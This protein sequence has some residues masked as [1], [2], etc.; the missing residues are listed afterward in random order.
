MTERKFYK[1]VFT[2][3]ILSE[4][5]LSNNNE[6][7]EELVGAI[8]GNHVKQL[9]WPRHGKIESESLE[10][11]GADMAKLLQ[12]QGMQPEF[13]EIDSN[14]DDIESCAPKRANRSRG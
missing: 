6:E 2:L 7:L 10:V 11:N 3:T 12:G 5:P 13:F 14:G 9:P 8:Y 1:S 4:K